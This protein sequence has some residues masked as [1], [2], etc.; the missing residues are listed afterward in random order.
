MGTKIF[1]SLLMMTILTTTA[2]GQMDKKLSKS[3]DANVVQEYFRLFESDELM[4]I[5]L[6]FDLSGYIRTKPKKEFLN[7]I[8]TFHSGEKDSINK[9]IRIRTRGE[10]RNVNC[11]FPPMELNLKKSDFKNSDLNKISK[12]KLVMQCNTG[13]DYESYLLKEYLIYKLYNVL[14]DT[15]FKVRLL[16]MNLFD[17]RKNKKPVRQYGFLIEPLEMLAARTNSTVVKSEAI[18]Q[19]SIRQKSMDRLA[20]FNYMVGNYDWSIP[21]Q[22]NVRVLK[23]MTFDTTGLGTAVPYDFDWTGLV[24]P[25]YAIPA[26]V[27]GTESVRQRIFLGICRSKEVYRQDLVEFIEKKAE[28]YKIVNEFPYLNQKSKLFITSYLDEF[29]RQINAKDDLTNIFLNS[30]KKF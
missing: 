16:S 2:L 25:P 28:F 22:H 19:K 12:I 5:S 24:D 23:S 6:R 9:E 15:C 8:L 11:Y 18:N 17:T 1:F 10:F 26:E 29:F 27:T 21:G 3:T 13:S 4:K 20:I 14:T 7:A 30:C